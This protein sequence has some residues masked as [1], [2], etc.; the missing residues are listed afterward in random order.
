MNL[1]DQAEFLARAIES[2]LRTV[3]DVIAWADEKIVQLETPPYWLLE[4]S[5]MGTSKAQDVVNVLREAEGVVDDAKV[6]QVYFG[7]LLERIGSDVWT[8]E[9]CC[10]FLYRIRERFTESQSLDIQQFDDRYDWLNEE[11][12]VSGETRQD[13]DQDLIGFLER[14]SSPPS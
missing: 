9:E 1:K 3:P 2:G 11:D 6:S 8:A 10:R 14:Q 5:L 13:I 7:V 12:M 4:L